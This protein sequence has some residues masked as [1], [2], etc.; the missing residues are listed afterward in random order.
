MHI[1]KSFKVEAEE[2]RG[3]QRKDALGFRTKPVLRIVVSD[4]NS[5]FGVDRKP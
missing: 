5:A 3:F 4:R 1:F 2:A